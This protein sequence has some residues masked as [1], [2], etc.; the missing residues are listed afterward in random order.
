MKLSEKEIRSY[1]T[2]D[3]SVEFEIFDT[4]GSTNTYLKERAVLGASEGLIAIANGQTVGRGRMGRSF[5]SPDGSGI[6]M[7]IL[8][9]PTS[10]A[11]D[12]V[13]ITACAAVAVSEAIEAVTGLT[14]GIKWVNDLYLNE[15]KV[16]GIL[17]EG[18]VS[19]GAYDYI[20]LGIG[21]NLTDSFRGTE[22][23]SIAGGLFPVL[24]V[25]ETY[26][27]KTKLI[28]E[29]LNR[30]FHYYS[31]GLDKDTVLREYRSRLFIIGSNV[32]VISYSDQRDAQVVALNDDFSL[33]VRF[34]DGSESSLQSGE[35]RL[36]IR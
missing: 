35:V 32:E 34:S 27:L 2:T 17:A 18:S 23:E 24:S 36:K 6:Y 11:S 28:A 1:L 8:L 31:S 29:I 12:S 25:D 16:C 26:S 22:L 10:S 21:V 3:K 33:K 5:S 19:N 30:F 13:K 7:S 20:V 15:K 14:V 4:L 9:R